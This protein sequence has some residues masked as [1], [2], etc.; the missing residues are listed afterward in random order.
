MKGKIQDVLAGTSVLEKI[1]LGA[2]LAAFL[3]V[4]LGNYISV[5]ALVFWTAIGCLCFCGRG[6]SGRYGFG[7]G[8]VFLL[9]LV[10]HLGAVLIIHTPVESDFLLYL[11]ASR[12]FAAGDYSFQEIP[13][14][15][16]WAGQ[17]GQVIVQGWLLRLWDK[18]FLLKLVNCLAAAGIDL[19]IYL[20]A[21]VW[22]GAR[23][24]CAAA[25]FHS[26]A[27]FPLTFVTVLS[28]QI[29]AAFLT[30]LALYTLVAP[31]PMEGCGRLREWLSRDIVR[32]PLAGVLAALSNIVRPEAI[33]L[34]TAVSAY[35]V[36]GLV[37]CWNAAG[38]RRFGLGLLLLWGAYLL[39][40]QGA[41]WAVAASGVNRNGLAGK[42]LLKL[43]FGFDLSTS[44][45]YSNPSLERING[46]RAQG[47]GRAEAEKAVLL[48]N[49]D[50]GVRDFIELF[51]R[52][53]KILW[54]ASGQ[55]WALGY[56]HND[57]PYLYS[58]AEKYDGFCSYG[59]LL[60]AGLGFLAIWVKKKP[61]PQSLLP[62]FLVFA[63]FAAYLLIEVQPR[64][65][66]VLQPA[67]YILA[68]GG[69]EALDRIHLPLRFVQAFH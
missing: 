1:F 41:S 18:I 22:F 34:L 39:V 44:G 12:Q 49:L 32:F 60:L 54:K 53:L 24:G 59:S 56:L 2:M 13:F 62:A 37:R 33:I 47:M 51:E 20:C 65:V 15:Q 52:K 67:L 40:F 35:C 9:S 19:L 55:S 25:V 11:N 27:M 61:L 66:Y 57:H 8:C 42:S 4:I 36:F 5:L 7:G 31:S 30:Y 48:E 28:N 29:L 17:T 26:L 21:R 46:L 45:Q 43:V 63:G 16:M 64:Y 10:V 6:L 38:L 14:F 58:C 23:A 50:M 68:A 3:W 69:L